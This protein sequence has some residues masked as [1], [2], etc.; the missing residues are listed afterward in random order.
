MI[1]RSLVHGLAISAW[2]L[3]GA[4]TVLAKNTVGESSAKTSATELC[5]S[6][7]LISRARFGPRNAIRD[8]GYLQT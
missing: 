2:L 5:S 7:T 1:L 8:P 4:D 3:G 6:E